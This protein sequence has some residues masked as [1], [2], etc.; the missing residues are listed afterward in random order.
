MKRSTIRLLVALILL[1]VPIYAIATQGSDDA[2]A[3]WSTISGQA[4]DGVTYE[5]NKTTCRMVF[6]GTGPMWNFEDSSFPSDD[7]R[8]KPPEWSG[9]PVNSAVFESGV[10][11]VG[12]CCFRYNH[13]LASVDLCD[14]MTS[15]G[16]NAFS[17]TA[18]TSI[19]IPPSVTFI[20][21]LAFSSSRLISVEVPDTVTSLGKS[22]FAKCVNLISLKL[23]N[24]ITVLSQGLIADTVKMETFVYGDNVTVVDR[25]LT[26]GSALESFYVSP[27]VR[28]ISP[29][30]FSTFTI[31][32]LKTIDVDPDN[33]I[34][35]SSDGMLFT[36]DMTELVRLLPARNLTEYKVPDTVTTISD[37]AFYNCRALTSLTLC[38]GLSYIGEAV[39]GNCAGLRSLSIPASVVQIEKGGIDTGAPLDS[40]YMGGGTGKITAATVPAIKTARAITLGPLVSSVQYD[41]LRGNPDL[42]RI[43]VVSENRSFVSLDGALYNA[44]GIELLAVPNAVPGCFVMPRS[45]TH[46]ADNAFVN[47]SFTA[48]ILGEDTAAIGNGA[49]RGT[50]IETVKI[51]QK[52]KI[53]GANAFRDCVNLKSVYFEGNSAPFIGADAFNTGAGKLRVYSSMFDGYLEG[54]SG[55]TEIL[56]YDSDFY[57]PDKVSEIVADERF[58]MGAVI[59]AAAAMVLSELIL[60]RRPSA[61]GRRPLR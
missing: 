13:S 22:A 35:A 40:I 54:T 25:W 49:F 19:D 9:Y 38:E 36:K 44:T 20:G 8:A 30:A 41:A 24:G 58:V 7:P 42:E 56:Y 4:G 37:K 51:P 18:I 5:L 45:A 53:I 21:N 46:I 29:D 27:T 50:G 1:S 31:D 15:I 3:D 55:N 60:V 28:W 32:N 59:A 23:G 10:T 47:S 26:A 34:Y 39:F 61:R 6:R 12:D 52:V 33:G 14:G 16:R 48:V 17:G 43:T 2:S 11:S 57:Y